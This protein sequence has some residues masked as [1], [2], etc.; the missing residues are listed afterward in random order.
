MDL[1][2]KGKS[3]LITGGSKG[4]G[5]AVADVLA[6]EGCDLHLAARDAAA[7]ETAAAELAEKF[8]AKV[9]V[10]ATDL[11][12]RA[13]VEDLAAKCAGVDILVNNAGA[14]PGGTIDDIDDDRWREGWD[15]KVFGYVTMTR[16]L[17]RAMCERGAGVIVNVV[18]AAGEVSD[19]S[20]ICGCAGNA[21]LIILT[22]SLGAVGIDHGVRVVGVNPGPISTDRI[23]TMMETKAEAEFGDRSRWREFLGHLPHGRAG[24]PQEVADV[25]AFLA[26]DRASYVNATLI[27]I[28]G[29]FSARRKVF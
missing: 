26:S 21:A 22:Q 5:R 15:L 18:G 3:A 12:R 17:Y 27:P 20:Y 24:T 23:R 1:N 6:A 8:G 7:L 28:D 29:G 14:I 16:A 4:I 10:H 25:V 11:S 9:E 13:N 19:A 2:L